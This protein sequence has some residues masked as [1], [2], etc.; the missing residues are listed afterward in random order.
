MTVI[1]A[2]DLYQGQCV[3]LYQG[4]FDKVT[5]YELN[6]ID[7]AKHYM[8][9]GASQIHL[10]DLSGTKTGS[11]QQLEIMT[12]I[13]ASIQ[14]QIQAGGGLRTASDITSI[15]EAGIDRAVVGSL[16]VKQPELMKDI[17]QQYGADRIVLAF[18][19]QID[20]QPI[21]AIHGWQAQSDHSLWSL[22]DSYASYSSLRIL[23][24]DIGCDGTL[25]GPNVALY[26]ECVQ[27]FP[28][29][30]FQASGGMGKLADI[31]ALKAIPVDDVI[32][33]KAL[34]E[35]S[36]TLTEAMALC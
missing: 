36:F 9:Q 29:F 35:S 21:I 27:R 18:D 23:C 6:P 17:I 7:V 13:K 19:V 14:C 34:Y 30:R 28:N 33:G 11:P 25:S 16:A 15:L 3:R 12:E 4:R 20:T 10:V 5:T 1:P 2:I 22:L 32:I 26:Q 24:T 31:S 8:S